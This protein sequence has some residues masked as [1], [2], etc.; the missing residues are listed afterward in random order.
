MQTVYCPKPRVPSRK[1]HRAGVSALLV[2]F[3]LPVLARAQGIFFD[4]TNFIVLG[5]GLAA[6]MADFGLRSVYQEKSFPAQMAQQMDVAFPQP[7]IQGAGVGSVPGFPRARAPAGPTG[8]C[9]EGFPSAA[10]C[11]QPFRPGVRVRDALTRRSAPP[12]VQRHDELQS[13]TNLILG[14]PSLI[15]KASHSGPRSSTRSACGLRWCS[16]LSAITTSWK[17]PHR[18]SSR[19]TSVENFR[20]LQRGLEGS[21]DA[22]DA[23]LIVLTIPDPLDTAYFTPLGSASQNVRASAADLQALYNLGPNDLL[24]PN[25]LTAIALQLDANEI[26]P[27]PPGS[28]IGADVA[29]QSV[30]A[31]VRSIRDPVSGPGER[32]AS[33]RPARPVCP[34]PQCGPRSS[35]IPRLDPR[36]F[37]G[38][39]S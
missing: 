3:L 28:V 18:R 1:Q 36:L 27:L 13:L 23:A 8:R 6:G 31:W 17:R 10:L 39:Y 21:P 16:S 12:L 15:L 14:Y 34:R 25:G 7:L 24:T 5:E 35:A 30:P 37:G 19:L 32:R 26:G 29:A 11:V 9:P 20:Q 38:F 33:L 22:T 4:P 2:L